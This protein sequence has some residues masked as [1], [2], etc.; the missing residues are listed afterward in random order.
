[1]ETLLYTTKNKSSSLET[2]QLKLLNEMLTLNIPILIAAS[3]EEY[4]INNTLN[5]IVN[6]IIDHKNY[7]EAICRK[8][9]DKNIFNQLE[10]IEFYIFICDNNSID[11]TIENINEFKIRHKKFIDYYKIN[12]F[13]MKET[14]PGKLNA[15]KSL[16]RHLDMNFPNS[17]DHMIFTDAE[18]EWGPNVYTK[19]IEF[20]IRNSKVKLIGTK[21]I[22]RNKTGFWG[23]LELL[24]Y[25][26]YGEAS[27]EGHGLFFKFISGMCYLADRS[28][29]HILK[30]EIPSIIG[31][32][33]VALSAIIGK[34]NIRILKNANIYFNVTENMKQFINIRGRHIREL[35]KLERWLK[36]WYINRFTEKY[37]DQIN[38]KKSIKFVKKCVKKRFYDISE[39]RLLKFLLNFYSSPEK[40]NFTLKGLI[41]W[42]KNIHAFKL[43]FYFIFILSPLGMFWY[44]IIK[45]TSFFQSFNIK[46]EGWQTIRTLENYYDEV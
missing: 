8:I 16:L 21:I 38:K 44:S 4:A 19:L 37:S 41:K 35:F 17:F 18:I 40:F 43:G 6:S 33:D 29:L 5:H 9:N 22:P 30:N 2:S 20:K 36:Q 3:N 25:Y 12:I 28:V 24:P 13:T 23:K 42:I 15:L 7:L 34:N 46:N 45:I 39:N 27:P 31:N 14:K 11:N 10:K 1:M 32:E 26:G